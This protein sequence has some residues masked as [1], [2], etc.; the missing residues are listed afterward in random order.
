MTNRY[1]YEMTDKSFMTWQELNHTIFFTQFPCVKTYGAWIS[2]INKHRIKIVKCGLTYI[3]T[4]SARHLCPG[5]VITLKCDHE[6]LRNGEEFRDVIWSVNS[7]QGWTDLAFCNGSLACVVTQS[8][9]TDGIKVLGISNGALTMNRTTRK[10]SSSHMDLQCEIDHGS[11]TS[12]YQVK[13]KLD[14]ECKSDFS[15]PGRE[16]QYLHTLIST[17]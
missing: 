2:K 8:G 3:G 12:K 17:L 13:I 14:V 4:V 10:A 5:E 1:L 15:S 6:A 16:W 9:V 7:S 11:H